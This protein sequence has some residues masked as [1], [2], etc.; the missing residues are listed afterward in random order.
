MRFFLKWVGPPENSDQRKFK[1]L[2]APQAMEHDRRRIA[3]VNLRDQIRNKRH[4]ISGNDDEPAVG[5]RMRGAGNAFKL[6]ADPG[7]QSSRESAERLIDH[8]FLSGAGL[9]SGRA[10]LRGG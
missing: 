5:K 7:D 4:L 1:Q 9:L 6:T 8:G 3:L 2:G 10:N